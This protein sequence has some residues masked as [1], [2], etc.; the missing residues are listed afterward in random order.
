MSE[1]DDYING[2]GSGMPAALTYTRLR[3]ARKPDPYNPKHTVEDWNN[4]ERLTINGF[5]ASSASQ[6]SPDGSREETSS[7][8]VLTIPDPNA[9]IRIGDRIENTPYDGRRWEVTGIPSNDVN[10]WTGWQPTLEVQLQEW[11]G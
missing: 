5:L 8:A 11:K 2:T 9:D 1:V 10:P 6:R 7:S 3:A 4:P